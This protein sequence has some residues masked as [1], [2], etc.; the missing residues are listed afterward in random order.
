MYYFIG[1]TLC[2]EYLNGYMYHTKLYSVYNVW[3]Y[4][5]VYKVLEPYKLLYEK[6]FRSVLDIKFDTSYYFSFGEYKLYLFYIDSKSYRG[7]ETG[8][9]YIEVI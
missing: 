1:I 4:L 3:M 5:D 9:F 2:H 8:R 6:Y 7:F